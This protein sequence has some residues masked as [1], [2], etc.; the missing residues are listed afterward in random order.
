VVAANPPSEPVAAEPK[1][2]PAPDAVPGHEPPV[3][4]L[5]PAMIEDAMHPIYAAA[6]ACAVEHKL[7]G[8]VKLHVTVGQDGLVAKLEQ[9]GDFSGTA[10]AACIEKAAKQTHFPRTTQR[11]TSFNY[12]MTLP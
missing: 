4:V 6:R 12:P 7:A 10:V 1:Q 8:K 5:T 11:E 2:C 9:V 3:D